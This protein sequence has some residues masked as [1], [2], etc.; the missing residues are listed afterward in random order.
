MPA[1]AVALGYNGRI[2]AEGLFG[3]ASPSTHFNVFSCTKAVL[4]GVVWQLIGEG[5]LS[6]H[7]RVVDLIPG[8][9]SNGTSAASAPDITLEHLLTHTAGFPYAPMGPSQWGTREGRLEVMS[10]WRL[11]FEP[12][13][14]FEYHATSAHWVVAEMIEATEGRDFREVVRDRIINPLGLTEFSLG[15]PVD[16]QP[17]VAELTLVGEPPTPAELEAIFGIPNPPMGEVTPE[18]LLQANSAEFRAG[19]LPGGGG[20]SDAASIALYY[21]AML[22]NTGDLWNPDVLAD[23]IGNIRCTLPEPLLNI[24]SNRTLGLKVA[25]SDGRTAMRGMGHEVSPAAFGH[26]GAGGQ[27]AWADPATGLSLAF[28]TSAVDRN[29]LRESSRTSAIA[30]R[31]ARCRPLAP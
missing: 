21:Q 20:V 24:E 15:L 30:T 22:H 6:P 14:R 4:A 17:E 12:G 16:Q 9:L 23:G 28:L 3:S 26:N 19:G 2:V 18:I 8:F 25:G 11:T 31:A 10:R 5:R 7:T 27:I 13:T 1:A 29:V